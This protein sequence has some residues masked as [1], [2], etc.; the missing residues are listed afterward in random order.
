MSKQELN[1]IPSEAVSLPAEPEINEM[2]PANNRTEKEANTQL[3]TDVCG[4]IDS[5]R[6][7][8]ATTVNAEI[9]LSRKKRRLKMPVKRKNSYLCAWTKRNYHRDGTSS[10]IG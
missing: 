4:I 2:H 1:K 10:P 6:Y 9:C 3:F 8:L 7:R 5:S